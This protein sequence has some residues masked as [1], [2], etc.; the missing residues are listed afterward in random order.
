MKT[1]K[2]R[3]AVAVDHSGAW[4]ASGWDT[5][6]DQKRYEQEAFGCVIE[7]LESGEA[8]YW[9]EAEL[10]VPEKISGTVEGTVVPVG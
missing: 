1:V 9:I 2:V 4:S 8:R 7:N 5:K 10:Q 6:M 3:I